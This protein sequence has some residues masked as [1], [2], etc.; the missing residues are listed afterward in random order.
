ML[1]SP[2]PVAMES[3][4]ENETLGWK[5]EWNAISDA[6][7]E[8]LWGSLISEEDDDNSGDDMFFTPLESPS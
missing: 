8:S 4:G 5:L 3:K 2:K 7:W 1:R 6:V